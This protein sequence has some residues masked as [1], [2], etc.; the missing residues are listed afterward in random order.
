MINKIQYLYDF[1]YGNDKT[2]IGTVTQTMSI[3]LQHR[4]TAIEVSLRS[5][6][7]GA[8]PDLGPSP[9]RFTSYTDSIQNLCYI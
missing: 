8:V 1:G 6:Q 2:I 9:F 4:D 5:L 3:E 7:K